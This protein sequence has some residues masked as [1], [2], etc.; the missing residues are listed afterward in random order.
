MSLERRTDLLVVLAAVLLGREQASA[1]EIRGALSRLGVDQSTQQTAATLGRLTRV[2]SPP[3][4]AKPNWGGP[5]DYRV[6]PAGRT[7]LHNTFPAGKL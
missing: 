1:D 3:F 7:W 5:S 6:T 4:E 2:A